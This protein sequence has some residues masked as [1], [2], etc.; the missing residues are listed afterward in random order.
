[1]NCKDCR[2]RRYNPES[3]KERIHELRCIV[4]ILEKEVSRLRSRMESLSASDGQRSAAVEED[5]LPF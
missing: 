3:L 4:E 2:W 1:M 5:D